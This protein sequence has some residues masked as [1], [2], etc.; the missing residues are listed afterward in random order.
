MRLLL[1]ADLSGR[2]IARALR[3]DG[4]DVTALTDHP[5]FEGLADDEVLTLAAAEE[6]ILVTRNSRD[7]APLL[8]SWAEAGRVHAGCVLIWTLKHD[9]Y[10]PILRG[11]RALLQARPDQEAWRDITMA[12]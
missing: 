5:A 10:G 3:R 12:L 7:F 9:D 1:D 8:R 2:R 11:L 6:R 4:H